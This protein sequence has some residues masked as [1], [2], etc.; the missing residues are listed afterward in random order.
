M[1]KHTS[2]EINTI[3]NIYIHFGSSMVVQPELDQ[4]NGLLM[5]HQKMMVAHLH[6]ILQLLRVNSYSVT[7]KLNVRLKIG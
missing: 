6:V 2:K 4:V 7:I 5:K 1:K 3:L